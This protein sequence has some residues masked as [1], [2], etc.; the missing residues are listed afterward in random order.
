MC[1]CCSDSTPL[2][3][4][5]Y[6]SMHVL[7]RLSLLLIS[8][9]CV[10]LYT[11]LNY[12]TWTF[13]PAPFFL[14]KLNGWNHSKAASVGFFLRASHQILFLTVQIKSLSKANVSISLCPFSVPPVNKEVASNPIIQTT[15]RQEQRQQFSLQPFRK[16][17]QDRRIGFSAKELCSHSAN[18]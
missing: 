17:S 7:I 1:L 5:L 4:S 10:H 15:N 13:F 16:R 8:T 2:I 6:V 18:G 11:S 14:L 12:E 9:K 3:S